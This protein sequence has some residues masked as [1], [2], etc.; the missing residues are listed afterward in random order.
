MEVVFL[1][2]A[3]IRIAAGRDRIRM[4]VPAGATVSSAV[5][6]LYA[7]HPSLERFRTTVRVAVGNEYATPD[8]I[9]EPDEEIS[10]IPPVQGG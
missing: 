6:R 10:L 1:L 8:R 7:E 5:D 3:Q 4:T 9:L 2:W